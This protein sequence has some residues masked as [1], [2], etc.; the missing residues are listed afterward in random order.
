MI[1]IKYYLKKLMSFQIFIKDNK[2]HTMNVNKNTSIE[3]IYKF[4]LERL[5][6]PKDFYYL[7]IGNKILDDDKKILDY[8][9]GPESTIHI[10]IR[11]SGSKKLKISNQ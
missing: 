7:S 10:I 4:I 1:Y 2:S 5:K 11:A 9:I 3:E 6:I 8:P